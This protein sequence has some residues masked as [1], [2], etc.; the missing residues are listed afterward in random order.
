MVYTALEDDQIPGYLEA[1]SKAHPDM[2][3]KVYINDNDI[4]D[5]SV[6]K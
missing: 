2:K 5:L 1:F 4:T 6:A 3:G